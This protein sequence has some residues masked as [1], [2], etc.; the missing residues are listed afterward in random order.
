[1]LWDA[2]TGEQRLRLRGDEGVIWSLAFSPDGKRLASASRFHDQTIRFWDLTTAKEIRYFFVPLE[3]GDQ[4]LSKSVTSWSGQFD[5][6]VLLWDVSAARRRLAARSLTRRE[7][8]HLW[9]DQRDTDVTKAHAALWSLVAAPQASVPFLNEQLRPVP[10]MAPERLRGL[11]ADL[12]AEGFARREDA[13]Q[14]LAQLSIEA[15]PALREV[16]RNKPSLEM[17]RRV[18][19]LLSNLVCQT[20]VSPDALRQLRAIQVLEQIGVPAVHPILKTLSGGVPAAPATR[21]ASAALARLG[22]TR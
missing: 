4:S 20:E 15:E 5:S 9:A 14:K 12:D 10:Q 21:D 16:L 6:T 17:R 1:M 22:A 13:S 18:E 8:D 19:A 11:V 7:L 2:V 3:K